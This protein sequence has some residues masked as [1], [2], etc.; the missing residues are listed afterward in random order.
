MIRLDIK[1]TVLLRPGKARNKNKIQCVDTSITEKKFVS[2]TTLF[3]LFYFIFHHHY[4]K[5]VGLICMYIYIYIFVFY[6]KHKRRQ[7]L[8]W[9]KARVEIR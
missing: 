3:I 2:I 1:K 5:T 8:P 7:A 6:I 4:H 9:Q